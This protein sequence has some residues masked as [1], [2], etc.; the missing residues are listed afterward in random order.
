MQCCEPS[1]H[2]SML[3]S[4]RACRR[5]GPRPDGP[6]RRT[7]GGARPAPSAPPVDGTDR[8]SVP[9]LP[10]T[11]HCDAVSSGTGKTHLATAVGVHGHRTHRKR[12]RF[13]S[14]VDL[15]NALEQEK[16]QESPGRSSGRLCLPIS[17]SSTNLAICRSASPAE[18]LLFHLISKLYE[19]TSLSSRRTSLS[20]IG[21]GLRRRQNDD[22][23][24]RPSDP[25][26]RHRRNRQRQLA[27]QKQ[28]LSPIPLISSPSRQGE[29]GEIFRTPQVSPLRS[30]Y[31]FPPVRHLR[32]ILHHRHRRKPKP[33]HSSRRIG[34]RY[35]TRT[36][37]SVARD[38]TLDPGDQPDGPDIDDVWQTFECVD[39]V[40][41]FLGQ[42][43]ATRQQL[44]VSVDIERSNTRGAGDRM[45]GIGVAVEEFDQILV[46]SSARR[47]RCG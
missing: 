12:G 9:R 29:R 17:S 20:P 30:G 33:R 46:L 4:G 39:G 23:H 40:L 44:L 37:L 35:W 24:A 8:R 2:P 47:G 11:R 31:A 27:L 21:R 41:P 15:V 42:F 5:A 10:D 36:G 3:E 14:T 13:F 18:Q 34:G 19:N 32:R 38:L 26:L 25:S 16:P 1:P 45:A 6:R 28:L 22:G 7:A 43:R